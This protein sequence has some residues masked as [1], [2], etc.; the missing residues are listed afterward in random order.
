VTS[1]ALTLD[2]VDTETALAY[3]TGQQVVTTA[4]NV[5]LAIALVALVFGWRG[6]VQL[7]STSYDN[8]RA[9]GSLAHDSP[10]P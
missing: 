7:L 5:L 9:R 4:W 8:V 2:H 3:S 1:A 10:A 6:G